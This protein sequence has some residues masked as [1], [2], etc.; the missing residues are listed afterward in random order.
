MAR[1]N[2][3]YAYVESGDGQPKRWQYDGQWYEVGPGERKL[4]P[5]AVAEQARAF[6]TPRT[7]AIEDCT[8]SVK[9]TPHYGEVRLAPAP[10][11]EDPETGEKFGSISELIEAAKNRGAQLFKTALG[12]EDEP[13][14]G[15]DEAPSDFAE[16]MRRAREAKAAAKAAADADRQAGAGGP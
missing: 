6:F 12:I 10:L 3:D 13:D 7:G 14:R 1:A 11:L 5:T 15:A 4:F 16:R 9:I 2:P 8:T